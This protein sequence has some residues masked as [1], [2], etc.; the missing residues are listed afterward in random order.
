MGNNPIQNLP[1]DKNIEELLSQFAPQPTSRFYKMMSA[2]PWQR[3][4]PSAAQRLS[5]N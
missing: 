5:I 2:A 3:Q 4:I 1:D